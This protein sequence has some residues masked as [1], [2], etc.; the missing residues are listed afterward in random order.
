MY[1]ND[2]K[3]GEFAIVVHTPIVQPHRADA[4]AP[5]NAY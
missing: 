4:E 1:G 2:G 5:G 3:V